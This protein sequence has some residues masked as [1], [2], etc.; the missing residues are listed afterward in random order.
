L[1]QLPGVVIAKVDVKS[2]DVEIVTTDERTGDKV[3]RET[4]GKTN[5]KV[6]SMEGPVRVKP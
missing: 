5:F 1:S 2:G 6:V 4:I 3:I